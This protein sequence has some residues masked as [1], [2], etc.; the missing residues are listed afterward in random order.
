MIRLFTI[1]LFD[2]QSCCSLLVVDSSE[3]RVTTSITLCESVP[4]PQP[5]ASLCVLQAHIPSADIPS[6]VG[7]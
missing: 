7:A 5:P 2:R 6:H 4:S 1:Y 3:T